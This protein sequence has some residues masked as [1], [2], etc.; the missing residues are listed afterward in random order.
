MQCL[1]YRHFQFERGHQEGML[2]SLHYTR[3]GWYP[4]ILADTFYSQPTLCSYS[5]PIPTILLPGLDAKATDTNW[6]TND[7][8]KLLLLDV[9]RE[10]MDENVIQIIAR[11]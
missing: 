1:S 8:H 5:D 7:F 9:W 10:W 4:S 11:V 6:M 2:S 3:Q